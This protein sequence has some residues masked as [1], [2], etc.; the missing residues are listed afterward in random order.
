MTN[1]WWYLWFHLFDLTNK[2]TFLYIFIPLLCV[3][4]WVLLDKLIFKMKIRK[5]FIQIIKIISK[6]INNFPYRI[7]NTNKYKK[8]NEY[9]DIV[10]K[11]TQTMDQ[12]A[13]TYYYRH[14]LNTQIES[15]KFGTYQE[16]LHNFRNTYPKVDIIQ[17]SVEAWFGSN[18]RFL[19]CRNLE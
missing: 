8:V 4:I 12:Y 5:W 15:K 11:I 2:E 19:H 18:H 13:I 14:I 1:T 10:V 17:E 6:T 3:I 7:L 16:C 9:K